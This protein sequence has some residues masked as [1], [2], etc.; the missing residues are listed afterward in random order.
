[1]RFAFLLYGDVKCGDLGPHILNIHQCF[2]I[3]LFLVI[4]KYV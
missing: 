3:F 2:L 1:M 4:V